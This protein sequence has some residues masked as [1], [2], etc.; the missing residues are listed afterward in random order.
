MTRLLFS[1]ETWLSTEEAADLLNYEV[2]TVR[3]K[4][5]KKEYITRSVSGA[6]GRG[7]NHLEFLLESLPEAAQKTY[8]NQNGINEDVQIVFN[9]D[10]IST[11]SQKEKGEK[12]AQAVLEFKRYRKEAQKSGMKSEVEIKDSFVKC[13]NQEHPDF[14]ITRKSLYDWLKKSPSGN[15]EKLVDKRGGYNRGQSKIPPYYQE[16]FLHHYLQQ[17]KPTFNG[18]FKR[19]QVEAN[20]NGE[21][22]PGKKAFSNL[23]NSIN[24]AIIA[25]AREGKKYFEDNFMPTASRDYSKLLPNDIWVSDHH[26]W[27]VFVRVPDGKGGWK[28]ERPWGS[29]WMDMRTRK[30]MFGFIRIES[31]NSDIVLLS[32]GMAVKR[33]GIPKR[34]LLDNGKDYQARDLFYP[35][36]HISKKERQGQEIAQHGMD[37][38]ELQKSCMSL[39]SN[40]HL[41]VTY[42]IPYN[43]RAKPIERFFD[44]LEDDFGKFYPSY[45]GSNAKKRPEDLKELDIMDMITLEE[46]IEHHNL[47]I[48][49]IYNEAPH[50]GNSMDDKSPNYWYNAI[51]FPKRTMS[52]EGLYFSLMRASRPLKVGKEGIRFNKELYLNPAF[53]NYVGTE[54]Y[55]RYNPVEPNKVFV[56]DLNENFLFEAPKHKK[57]GFD[58]SDEDY[59]EINHDKKIARSALL[60]GWK[61][62]KEARSTEAISRRIHSSEIDRNYEDV[63]KANEKVR[64]EVSDRQK[65][66][67]DNFRQKMLERANATAKQA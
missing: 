50:S 21:S 1:K 4:A 60:N 6:K 25:R 15:S 40:L 65:G 22:I 38:V 24:P 43:A 57:Y 28:P 52:D 8:Y 26:L 47:Y 61:P 17:S 20:K 56:Y 55:V 64:K 36:G 42:A 46:F 54:V 3:K 44:T 10:Y 33:W 11:K 51:D 9:Q 67:I 66:Y 53:Q 23:V 58:L 12:R 14:A 37:E 2:S 59:A 7:G 63:L 32:F 16:Y 5:A 30:I 45:A 19:T 39:A 18:C 49:S 31:P 48:E 34:V 27:D 35:E 13:W 41:E 29:Y 62:A